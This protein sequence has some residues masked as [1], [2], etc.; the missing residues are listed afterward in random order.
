MDAKSAVQT[1]RFVDVSV[2]IEVTIET[3]KS[4]QN[5]GPDD[6]FSASAIGLTAY[7][8]SA[9]MAVESLKAAIMHSLGVGRVALKSK[10]IME[11]GLPRL[12]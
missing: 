9:D 5:V 7:G 6:Y 8:T 2:R 1:E 10:V 3:F 4:G 12:T 11:E